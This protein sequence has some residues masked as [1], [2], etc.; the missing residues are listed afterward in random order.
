MRETWIN[1][2]KPSKL[3]LPEDDIYS[4]FHYPYYI[5]KASKTNETQWCCDTFFCQGFS[6]GWLSNG[7]VAWW[8]ATILPA[9]LNPL[10]GRPRILHLG[11][12]RPPLRGVL[13]CKRG[14]SWKSQTHPLEDQISQSMPMW[15]GWGTH[16][17]HLLLNFCYERKGGSLLLFLLFERSTLNRKGALFILSPSSQDIHIQSYPI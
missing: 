3:I 17:Y 16:C 8:A 1:V 4:H 9:S 13:W 10:E 11:L 12:T 14:L 2:G 5:S 6:R 7:V 15:D